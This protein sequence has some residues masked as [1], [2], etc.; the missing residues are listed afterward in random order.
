MKN[1][2]AIFLLV[3]KRFFRL[4]TLVALLV[5]LI[6]TTLIF[7]GSINEFQDSLS[8]SQRFQELDKKKVAKMTNYTCYSVLG[9]KFF[10]VPSAL[11]K[12]LKPIGMTAEL[13]GRVDS[14]TTLEILINAKSKTIF[15]EDVISPFR[16]SFLILI[17]GS[18]FVLFL[19][20]NL[21]RN[22]E[23]M[24]TLAGQFGHF[25]S[26][27]YLTL[28]TNILITLFLILFLGILILVS[29]LFGIDLSSAAVN[30]LLGY[31]AV[32][33]IM[34]VSFYFAGV[35]IG[36]FKNREYSVYILLGL[37]AISVFVIPG[38]LNAYISKRADNIT[39]TFD[40]ELKQ[41]TILLEYEQEMEE[42]YGKADINN[43]LVEREN[44]EYYYRDV[45]PQIEALEN[46]LK[47]EI[48]ENIERQRNLSIWFP[49]T[50]FRITGNYAS[51]YGL[52][53]YLIFYSK[54]QGEKKGFLRFMIDRVVYNDPKV[55]VSYIDENHTN[56]FYATSTLP[57]N[58]LK[59]VAI[60]L[61]YCFI[62]FF[63]AFFRFKRALCPALKTR[64]ST[65]KLNIKI[66]TGE[67]TTLHAYEPE[68]IPEIVNA[69]FG[70]SKYLKG[71][72]TIDDTN[73]DTSQKKNILYLPKPSEIPGDIKTL[74]LLAF[75]KR[76]LK[77][78]T[79]EFNSLKESAGDTLLKRFEE[80]KPLQ[81]GNVLLSILFLGKWD[82]CILY[83]FSSGM[84][85][86][87]QFE[88]LTKLRTLDL[89]DKTYLLMTFTED[90]YLVS[91]TR[92][93]IE[94]KDSHYVASVLVKQDS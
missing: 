58:F 6:V 17:L 60:N 75:F 32:I 13:S 72:I 28:S 68:I 51:G 25:K 4:K 43:I 64:I 57:V 34:Y 42:K 61:G 46:N 8:K 74:D 40:I 14:L 59:G 83:N 56:L 15:A 26:F 52:D 53:N 39:S 29:T 63:V 90:I 49:T 80:L 76:S 11:G 2:F 91:N 37:W 38:G 81:I 20:R 65:E 16:L 88:L 71:K 93:N 5:I 78:S 77:L 7:I 94:T 33:W 87:D 69:F 84:K 82:T 3:L 31:F 48:T 67:R 47:C 62:L 18:L 85:G 23:F 27:V 45:Y 9:V 70:V 21:L 92:I 44:V 41:M 12:F 22:K 79:D 35:I 10:Y 89:K 1:L 19:G 30:T 55:M 86:D 50:F 36:S 66:K 24:K 73:L 54:L